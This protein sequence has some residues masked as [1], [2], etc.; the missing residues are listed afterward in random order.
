MW[1]TQVWSLGWEDPLEKEMAIHSST[2]AWKIPWTEEPGRLQSMGSQRLRH[3]WATSRHFI[4]VHIYDFVSAFIFGRAGSSF[5]T[6]A[7]SSCGTQASHCGDFSCEAQAL[8]HQGF[9]RCGSWALETSSTVARMGLAA[10]QHMGSSQ[11][12]DWT[13]V[14]CLGRRILIHWAAKEAQ[15]VGFQCLTATREKKKKE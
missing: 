12:R 14:S 1:K 13:C 9:G 5:C 4:Y 15:I 10:P 7:F 6:R 3:D 8:G 2:V 11:L